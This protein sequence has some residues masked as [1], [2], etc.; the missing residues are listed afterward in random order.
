M[1]T[2]FLFA[3]IALFGWGFW[4]FF[5]ELATRHMR[6]ELAMVVSYFSGASMVLVYILFRKTEMTFSTAG[7]GYAV[8]GGLVSGIGA[9]AFYIGLSQGS[10]SIVTTVSALYFAVAVILGVTLL[11]DSLNVMNILGILFALI[12]VVLLAQ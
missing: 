6:P 8:I 10:T 4:A 5:A 11:G 3:L 2:A 7:F 9:V 12:A 1:S